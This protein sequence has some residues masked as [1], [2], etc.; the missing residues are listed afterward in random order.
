MSLFTILV[1]SS[2]FVYWLLRGCL[3]AIGPEERILRTLQADEWTLHR[4]RILLRTL[5]FPGMEIGLF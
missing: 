3:V 4:L 1:A 5:L 2:M